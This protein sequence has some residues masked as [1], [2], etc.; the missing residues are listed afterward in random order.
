MYCYNIIII[1]FLQ[2]IFEDL[3]FSVIDENSDSQ[4]I[5]Y[6]KLVFP[7]HVDYKGNVQK[8]R[9]V[10]GILDWDDP[11]FKPKQKER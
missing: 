8:R 4:W 5:P 9:V 10:F 1:V 11:S 2:I 3:F 7:H 6:E